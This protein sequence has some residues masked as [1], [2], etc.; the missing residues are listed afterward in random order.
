MT[1]AKMVARS[2]PGMAPPGASLLSGEAPARPD[3][4]ADLL[5]GPLDQGKHRARGRARPL[6]DLGP[7]VRR[8]IVG[9]ASASWIRATSCV[10]RSCSSWRS[11]ASL[12][13][14]ALFVQ[15]A[16]RRR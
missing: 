14:T 15:G 12:T 1:V 11:E 10:T 6:L 9:V 7:I 16:H 13:A 5:P 3:V 8:A 2:G 4:G